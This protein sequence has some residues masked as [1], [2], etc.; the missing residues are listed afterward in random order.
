LPDD[1]VTDVLEPF[2]QTVAQQVSRFLQFFYSASQHTAVDQI[3]LAGGCA[4]LAGV[5]ATVEEF[6]GITIIVANP[7]SG[8]SSAPRVNPTSLRNDASSLMIACG[9]A[10]R[11]FH[12]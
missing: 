12:G 4:S 7:F 11:S 9:L 1:Y 2:K 6:L 10:L 5:D 3:I 8:M